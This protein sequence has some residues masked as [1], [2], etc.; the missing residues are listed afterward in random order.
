VCNMTTDSDTASYRT[1]LDLI[2]GI[3]ITVPVNHIDTR[4]LAETTDAIVKDY[5]GDQSL[6]EVV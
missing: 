2:E 4:H 1:S 6:L 5:T 3:I